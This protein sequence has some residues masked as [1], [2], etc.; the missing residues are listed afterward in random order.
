MTDKL[1]G[2]SA[3][4]RNAIENVHPSLTNILCLSTFGLLGVVPTIGGAFHL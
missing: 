3:F 2:A 4:F 1:N